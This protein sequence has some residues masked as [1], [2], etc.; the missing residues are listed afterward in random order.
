MTKR[1]YRKR[2]KD[3]IK[4]ETPLVLSTTN[5]L[6]HVEDQLF[7]FIR[8]YIDELS[9]AEYEEMIIYAIRELMANANKANLKRLYFQ[10]NGLDINRADQYRQ[11]MSSFMEN[12]YYDLQRYTVMMAEQ[13]IY[14]KISFLVQDDYLII[15]IANNTLLSEEEETRIGEKISHAWTFSS[16]AEAMEE[17]LDGTEGAG[18]GIVSIIMMLKNMGITEKDSLVIDMTESDTRAVMRIPYK[19]PGFGIPTPSIVEEI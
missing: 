5:L 1:D 16:M 7:H 19:K 6:R 8:M 10:E 17:I 13:N 15:S 18:L 3:S 11:G 2:V 14:V 9:L 4:K 12:A